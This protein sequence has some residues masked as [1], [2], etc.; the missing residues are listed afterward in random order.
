MNIWPVGVRHMANGARRGRP[1][2]GK[3]AAT[4]L[5]LV[6]LFS[7]GVPA[8]PT[9]G[10]SPE[11]VKWT[12]VNIPAAGEAGNFVLA[13]GSDVRRLVAAV[14]GALYA[15]VRGLEFTLYRSGD[16]GRA[17][18]PVGNV[19]DDIVD[20]ATSPRDAGVVYYATTA[21]VLG[22]ADGG[23][24]FEPRPPLPGDAGGDGREITSL[25]VAVG[26]DH[27]IAV[28]AR[29][30]DDAEF[31]GVYLLDE[32]DAITNWTDTG[33]GAYDAYAVAFSPGYS[34]D[35]QL[36][37]VVTDEN[38]SFVFTRVGDAAWNTGAGAARL[39]R[40][41]ASGASPVTISAAVIACPAGDAQDMESAEGAL[42]VAV[43][44]GGGD[45]DAYRI[46]GAATS[47]ATDLNVGAAY[48]ENN[49]D[50]TGLA[51]HAGSGNITLLAIGADARTYVSLDGGATWGRDRKRPTGESGA[52]ALLAAGPGRMYAATGGA[53]SAVSVS[54]DAG[55]TW[56]QVGLI[57]I[58][59][60]MI[61]DVAPSPH[62]DLDNT[63]FLLTF[64]GGHSLWR[65]REGGASWERVL[66]GDATAGDIFS[67]VALPPGYGADCQAVF[68]A[69]ESRGEPAVWESQDN[70][71]TFRRRF[72]RDPATGAPLTIDAWA[73]TGRTS[74]IL[75][76][77]DGSHGLLYTTANSGLV[78]SQGAAAGG[79][80]I[81]AIT[82]S[83]DFARDRTILAG[84]SGGRA[85]LSTDGG[86]AFGPLP[87]SPA[88]PFADSPLMV[89]FDPGFATN[90]TVYAASE[91]GGVYRF[92]IGE[93]EEWLNIDDTPPDA[94]GFSGLAVSGNG[95]LYV[96]SSAAGG[97]LQRCLNP[98]SAAG[99]AFESVNGGLGQGAT[100]FGLWSAGNRVWS[101]DT[102]GARL[103][104]FRDTLESALD[105]VSPDDGAGGLG[106]L[107]NH[108][109][110]DVR[111]DWEAGE[112]ATGYQWQC[113]Y[114]TDFSDVPAGLSGTTSASSVRLPALE[115]ATTYYWR[116]RA[117]A[118]VMGPWSEKR[119]F[120]TTLDTEAVTLQ[121]ESPAPGAAGVPVQPFF[122]WTAVSGADAYELL[123]AGDPD[124]GE[125]NVSRTGDGAIPVNAWQCDVP[126]AYATGYYWKVRAVSRTTHSPWSA[127][128]VFTTEPEPEAEAPALP[129]PSNH[130]IKLPPPASTEPTG[131]PAA[132]LLQAAPPAPP[133]AASISSP[134]P[135]GY[136]SLPAWVIYLVGGLVL[137]VILSLIVV[138][139]MVQK[140]RRY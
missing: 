91:A 52:A 133:P 43:A 100:L 130:E 129:P 78:F 85:Y 127:A 49:I 77:Y 19:R 102:T 48:G 70:G 35:R 14:D 47:S 33:L 63:I 140:I 95:T 79:R 111:L 97:G 5:L 66:C 75:G 86:L 92:V 124:F 101:I 17:W 99:A 18:S 69:G 11:A 3:K 134:A 4:L 65:S 89:A 109:V 107:S 59:A 61:V 54:Q 83:P 7:T 36:F 8:I 40:D 62:A 118:P 29:D 15:A 37:A 22:S 27:V 94:A 53:G 12:K 104:L 42:Y 132:L 21:A 9:A 84:D 119:S 139:A 13:P 55:S 31:G 74:F 90:H 10:A 116:A 39:D 16:G 44:T 76:S 71:R 46:D 6:L 45:G 96:A 82:V 136:Y 115:P 67:R 25:A 117:S 1:G 58:Y 93:S 51:A 114:E 135:D 41:N 122:Q 64:G 68:V 108:T 113:N 28:A 131:T 105:P 30:A 103:M 128:G 50:I 72:P 2:K 138:L 112:G 32:A 110:R 98:G 121:P 137:T 125:P 123:V 126:L 60:D 120:T 24:T 80:P 34:A 38:N 56:D 23:R 20:I 73:V 106:T 57:D 88:A 87:A 81:S 26:N